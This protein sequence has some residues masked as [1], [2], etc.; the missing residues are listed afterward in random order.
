MKLKYFVFVP[1]TLLLVGAT[2]DTYIRE[3]VVTHYGTGYHHNKYGASGLWVDAYM[4]IAAS[5]DIPY[6][7]IVEVENIDPTSRCRGNKVR[8]MVFDWGPSAQPSVRVFDMMP[9]GGFYRYKGRPGIAE[10]GRGGV[11]VKLTVVDTSRACNPG[12]LGNSKQAKGEYF[13]LRKN[14]G[15]GLEED[16][17]FWEPHFN[18]NK[19]CYPLP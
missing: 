11:E 16:E 19:E 2:G 14:F 9:S 13:C 8:V 5:R 4:P 6:G 15:Y 17:I 12:R 7:T 18:K 3:G 1:L 10:K